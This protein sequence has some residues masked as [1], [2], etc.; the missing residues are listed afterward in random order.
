[1]THC[2]IYPAFPP[3]PW[4]LF[5]LNAF[6]SS[7]IDMNMVLSLKWGF[8]LPPQSS[9]C[10]PLSWA[11]PT[12]PTAQTFDLHDELSRPFLPLLP[13]RELPARLQ[14]QNVSL[15]R[16]LSSW[17]AGHLLTF[18]LSPLLCSFF[19]K[20]SF[21]RLVTSC[22]ICICKKRPL[23]QSS[24]PRCPWAWLRGPHRD[25]EVAKPG[26]KGR[27]G[28]T[29]HRVHFGGIYS[30]AALRHG[31]EYMR[32]KLPAWSC[33]LAMGGRHLAGYDAGA[34]WRVCGNQGRL[35]GGRD[36]ELS[37]TQV[38]PERHHSLTV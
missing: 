8:F 37:Q 35:P 14:L 19:R 20:D 24:H 1:M 38:C 10:G 36:P 12:S 9:S 6:S 28:M 21:P 32:K 13:C 2:F 15:C 16:R 18:A 27:R 3:D 23:S 26:H 5:L 25:R 4:G 30:E 29:W 11:V 31:W 7:N 17:S 34:T 22:F 33:S